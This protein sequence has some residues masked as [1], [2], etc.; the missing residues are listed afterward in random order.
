MANENIIA[1]KQQAVDELVEKFENSASA[2]IVSTRGLTVS[3]DTKLRSDLRES[4]VEFQVIKNSLL[5]RAADKLGYENMDEVFTGPTAV[6]FSPEDVAAPA[7]VLR[8]A[9]KEN[10]VI[11][12]KG[13]VVE[14]NPVGA[15]QISAIA[16]LPSKEELYSMLASAVQGPI[17]KTAG[18]FNAL[19][20]NPLRDA[21][22]TI[23]ALSEKK[24]DEGAA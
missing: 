10:D 4:D 21:M 7:K 14:Q 15:S 24:D 2:I 20:E 3:E 19:A 23:K 22:L 9:A 5:R 17:R 11:V 16:D 12:L 1:K 6:A 18:A 13:G 8:D